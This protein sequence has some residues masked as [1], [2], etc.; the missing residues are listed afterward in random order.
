M[1][2]RDVLRKVLMFPTED[3]FGRSG[4]LGP[5]LVTDGGFDTACGVNWT[6]GLG[7][8]IGSSAATFTGPNTTQNIYNVAQ[9]GLVA[10]KTY[11][12]E[13]VIS[14]STATVNGLRV[15]IWIPGDQFVSPYFRSVG[16]HTFTFTP[17]SDGTVALFGYVDEVALITVDSITC[18]QVY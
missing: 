2:L 18:R 6:C 4:G 9:A 8:A 17:S 15:D 5:E 14:A 11:V 16:T 1:A 7:W 3:I 13:I 10:G 12:I